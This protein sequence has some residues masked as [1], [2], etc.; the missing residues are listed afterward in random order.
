MVKCGTQCLI[1][2]VVALSALVTATLVNAVPGRGEVVVKGFRDYCFS[3]VDKGSVLQVSLTPPSIACFR[4]PVLNLYMWLRCE[5][6][7]VEERMNVERCGDEVY[8]RVRGDL[9]GKIILSPSEYVLALQLNVTLK[10]NCKPVLNFELKNVE[11]VEVARRTIRGIE[12]FND[13][14]VIM[15]TRTYCLS[16]VPEPHAEMTVDGLMGT[17]SIDFGTNKVSKVIKL[18]FVTSKDKEMLY[19]PFLYAFIDMGREIWP[20][21]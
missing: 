4:R 11:E 12:R 19:N 9:N 8:V 14:M 16:L 21:R 3:V 7:G 2:S 17:V 15:C 1:V 5:G 10:G 13:T 20:M 6:R 18:V